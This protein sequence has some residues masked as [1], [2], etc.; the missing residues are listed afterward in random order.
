MKSRKFE[1]PAYVLLGL[2]AMLV[3]LVGLNVVLS[4]LQWR[5]DLTEERAFTLSEGT[6]QI[7]ANL[8]SPVQVRFYY[9]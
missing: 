9:S 2:G 6:R 1:T 8:K 7:L 4:R 5:A 3:L